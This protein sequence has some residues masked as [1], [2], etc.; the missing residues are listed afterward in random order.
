MLAS[1]LAAALPW[2]R[3]P[4]GEAAA[5]D[6]ARRPNILFILT[7]DMRAD[8]LRAMPIVGEH[9]AAAGA[10]FTNYLATTPLC[11]P[12]RA[13]ILRGQYAHN[14]GVLNN[15]GADGGYATFYSRGNE[16][17]TVATWLHDRGYR[18][19]LMGK[20][21]NGYPETR[22]GVTDTAVPPGWD[23]WAAGM[24]HAPY[25]QFRYQLNEGGTVVS[26]G[27]S[28]A[29][30]LTDVLAEKAEAFVREAVADAA[31]FFLYLAPYAPHSPSIPAPRDAGAF[32]TEGALRVPSF[33]EADVS[34]KPAWVRDIPP[35]D[36]RAREIDEET[37]ARLR[38]LLAVDEMT[39]RLIAALA[40][41]GALADTYV[42][43][44]S[45]NGVLLGEHRLSHGKRA[46]YEEVIRMPLLIRGP[47]VAAGTTV[48]DVA[49]N[50]D[51]GPTFADLA[52]ATAAGFI[53][54]RSLAPLLLRDGDF[55]ERQAGL[56]EGFPGSDD[57]EP[58]KEK[59]PPPPFAALRARDF[60]YIEY[61]T[62]ERELYD[63]RAD[64]Y[65]TENLAALAD[66]QALATLS[67]RLGELRRCRRDSCRAAETAPLAAPSLPVPGAVGG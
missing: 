21:L 66:P 24:R 47:G 42:V 7:D 57:E 25:G 33:N 28:P 29:D 61:A 6:A 39:G 53:D 41:A 32:A 60:V 31:P 54:G 37:Q 48:A 22:K 65:E 13:S 50:I 20:Y 40:E 27:S 35:R 4:L 62:G 45:D 2:T 12:S 3:A 43:F 67:Q 64:P 15:T 1:L 30:Y 14:H 5:P 10:T 44:S 11:S 49:L 59:N 56:V 9:I 36:A 51:L 16:A 46:A 63:L 38:T 17:S 8:D 18:T 55:V 26:Y 19:A 58:R 34:D 23:R 52:E